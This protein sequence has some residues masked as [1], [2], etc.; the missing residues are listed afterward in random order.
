VFVFDE[1]GNYILKID[2]KGQGP[3]EYPFLSDIR[4]NPSTNRLELMCAM[5]FIYEY[6][7]SGKFIEKKQRF[8]NGY[9]TAAH[10]FIPLNSQ[11]T[12]LFSGFAHPFRIIYYNNKENKIINEYY[13]EHPLLGTVFINS[14]YYY[15][16]SWYFYRPYDRHI[17]KLNNDSINIAYTWDFG[18]YN[19]D[20]KKAKLSIETYHESQQKIHDEITSQFPYC[21]VKVGENNR[22]I[23]AYIYIYLNEV[24][25][26]VLFDKTIQKSMLIDNIA[27]HPHIVTNSHA[28]SYCNV[29]ELENNVDV[30]LLDDKNRKLYDELINGDEDVNPIIIKYNFK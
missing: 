27:I 10:E 30:N 21:I 23:I 12:V 26:T 25:K 19:R 6:D 17:H 20:V 4:I 15:K 24:Y 16:D 18:K 3:G 7:F 29:G 28:L 14:F 2:N 5:G 13:E 11:I 22:Y 1:Q 8:T 9:L